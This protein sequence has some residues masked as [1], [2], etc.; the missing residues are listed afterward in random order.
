MENNSYTIELYDLEENDHILI[1]RATEIIQKSYSQEHGNKVSCA[2]M[3]ADGKIFEGISIQ[4]GTVTNCAEAGAISS[5]TIDDPNNKIELIV[6]VRG[7]NQSVIP[8]CG[9]C[10]ELLLTTCPEAYAIVKICDNKTNYNDD[11]NCNEEQ[12]LKKVKHNPIYKKI[13]IKS[14]LPYPYLST[15]SKVVLT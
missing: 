13:K 10:R 5:M 3:T 1:N 9:I 8:P 11:N 2:L 7:K 4:R 15:H 12:M 6:A 14:L